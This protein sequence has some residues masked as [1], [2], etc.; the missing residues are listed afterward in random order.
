[1]HI[2]IEVQQLFDTRQIIPNY[3]GGVTADADAVAA[4]YAAVSINSGMVIGDFNAFDRAVPD[5]FIAV[6]AV[7]FN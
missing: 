4:Q 3:F 5:A 6:P 7:G 2:L 1:V